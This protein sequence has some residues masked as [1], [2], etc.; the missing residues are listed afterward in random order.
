MLY[1]FRISERQILRL[2][3]RSIAYGRAR[4]ASHYIPYARH[5]DRRARGQPAG[6][7]RG[8]R[9]PVV[10]PRFFNRGGAG[11]QIVETPRWGVSSI[12]E[13]TSLFIRIRESSETAHRAV[14]T[15]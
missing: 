5:P 10:K 6:H 11:R 3:G 8:R 4:F 12:L 1:G 9:R 14:S 13:Y 7:L 2:A 15:S